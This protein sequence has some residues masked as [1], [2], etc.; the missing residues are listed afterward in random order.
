V[1]V[2]PCVV[3]G[4]LICEFYVWMN[5]LS[6]P[7]VEE[8]VGAGGVTIVVFLNLV[9]VGGKHDGGGQNRG[10]NLIKNPLKG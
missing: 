7:E 9:V 3:D 5:L 10:G 1:G 6:N 4:G 2:A 8:E